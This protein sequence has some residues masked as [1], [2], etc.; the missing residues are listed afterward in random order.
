MGLAGGMAVGLAITAAVGANAQSS[1]F[2]VSPEQLRINQNISSA[3]V[4]RSNRSLNY[5]A[6]IRTTQ[7]DNADNGSQGVKPLSG[8]PGAGQGWTLG[9]LAKG[10][11]QFWANVSATGA[12]TGSSGPASGT[13]AFSATRSAAGN[14]VVDFKTNVSTCSWS[15]ALSVTT[16]P[17]APTIAYAIPEAG[18]ATQVNLRTVGYPAGVATL[19][20]SAFTVQV[21]C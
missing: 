9:Q 20:D 1:N 7:S 8:I 11:K 12:L 6:P 17:A 2:T 14:Y 18:Q 16:Q 13:G 15:A 19:T 3:A 5:L 10:Q 4:K 21:L